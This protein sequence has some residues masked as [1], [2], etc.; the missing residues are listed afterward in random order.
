MIFYRTRSKL[1]IAVNANMAGVISAADLGAVADPRSGVET[2]QIGTGNHGAIA[3][4]HHPGLHGI[5]GRGRR[6][7]D[8]YVDSA[9]TFEDYHYWATVSRAEEK[10]FTTEKAGLQGIWNMIFGKSNRKSDAKLTVG[11]D[12][13]GESPS[14]ERNGHDSIA[15]P[16]DG[17]IGEKD[18]IPVFDA[19][20]SDRYGIANSEWDSA[21]RALR[22]ATWGSV[23]YLITTDILGPY[24]VPYAI[25]RTGF[26]V[27][28]ALYTVFGGMVRTR[29]CV[30]LRPG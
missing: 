17:K 15:K 18:P 22:N 12:A 24:N 30:F 3:E 9:I 23:F 10:H 21:Q 11:H 5:A 19:S 25:S 14:P 28:F 7:S 29:I 4:E 20:K 13:Q 26:G 16:D 27:G 1:D 2:D 8:M 6:K